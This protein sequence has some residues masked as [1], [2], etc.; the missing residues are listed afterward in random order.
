M[1][2][3]G[4]RAGSGQEH[5]ENDGEAMKGEP[6]Q[7]DHEA[8][9]HQILRDQGTPTLS[10]SAQNALSHNHF[11]TWCSHCVSGRARHPGHYR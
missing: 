9:E 5:V 1:E 6:E 3:G 2:G 10:E 4:Q 7:Y 11:R 8:K